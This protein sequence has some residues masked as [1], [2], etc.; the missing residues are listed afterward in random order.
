MEYAFTRH[1]SEDILLQFQVR[2][3]REFRL[4]GNAV[5]GC[6][7]AGLGFLRALAGS[8]LFATLS[9]LLRLALRLRLRLVLASD[10]CLGPGSALASGTGL[11]PG[12]ALAARAGLLLACT[13][14]PDRSLLRLTGPFSKRDAV[15][16]QDRADIDGLGVGGSRGE[17]QGRDQDQFAH[18]DISVLMS[19]DW[20]TCAIWYVVQITQLGSRDSQRTTR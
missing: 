16:G 19:G 13:A 20:P 18:D 1:R 8:A 6:D 4:P 17:N 12:S 15:G 7:P 2:R 9:L 3:R 14:L 11:R 5:S 10:A